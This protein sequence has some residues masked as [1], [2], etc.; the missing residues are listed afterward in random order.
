MAEQKPIIIKRVKKKSGEGGH[1]GSWKVAYADFVTAMMA[2]FLL[3]W[4]ITMVSPEKRARVASYFKYYAIFEKSGISV[5]DGGGKDIIYSGGEAFNIQ[6]SKGKSKGEKKGELKPSEVKHKVAEVVEKKLSD[7][8]EQIVVE[9][10]KDIARIDIVDSEG[11]PIFHIG[12]TNLTPTGKKIL[13][14]LMPIFLDMNNK[15]IIEGHTDALSYRTNKY[16][17]WELSVERASAARREM[18]SLGLNPDMISMVTGY[19]ATRPLIKD[20]PNDYR[21]RR[22]SIVILNENHDSIIGEDIFNYNENKN[23]R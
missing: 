22:I 14:E 9:A 7:L 23:N 15:I 2:F 10:F 12:D 17:N 18:E 3:M 16:S 5:L 21:N 11:A 20:N 1:G 19:A 4:L 8:K 6:E 13:K